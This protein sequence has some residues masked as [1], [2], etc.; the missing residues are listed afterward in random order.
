MS[1][2]TQSLLLVVVILSLLS[3]LL[4]SSA[5]VPTQGGGRRGFWGIAPV[6]SV[7]LFWG[8]RRRVAGLI[9]LGRWLGRGFQSLAH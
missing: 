6:V 1:A 9:A 8:R 4:T 2:N 7:L 5:V 3:V